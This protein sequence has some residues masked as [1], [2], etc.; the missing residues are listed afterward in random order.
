MITY[1][2]RQG[3]SELFRIEPKTGT[4]YTTRGLDFE[5]ENQHTLIIG[6]LENPTNEKGATTR[7]VINI[8]DRND[9]PPVFTSVPRPITLDDE[10]NIGTRVINLIATDSDGTSPGNKVRY[11]LIGRGK[12]SKYFQIDPDT[13]VVIVRDDLRKETDSEYTLDIRAYDLGEPQLSSTISIQIYVRHVATVAPEVGL[14]FVDG[15]YSIKVDEGTP[16]GTLLKTLTI[17]N[18][19]AHSNNIPLKCFIINGNTESKLLS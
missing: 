3:P 13:G 19:H 17:V 16:P 7:V 2:I 14:G 8:E 9:I 15:A 12:S 5:R 11:E 4:I 1:I 6:T 10:V 18:N